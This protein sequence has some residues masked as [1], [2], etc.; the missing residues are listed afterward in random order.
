MGVSELLVRA[1]KG[2]VMSKVLQSL[3]QLYGYSLAFADIEVDLEITCPPE[4]DTKELPGKAGE[5]PG[6]EQTEPQYLTGNAKGIYIR[7]TV[8]HTFKAK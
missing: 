2:S 4:W 5:V 7:H 1:E 3:H 6:A 8:L